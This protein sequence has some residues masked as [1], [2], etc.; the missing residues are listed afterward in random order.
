MPNAIRLSAILIS[1]LLLAAPAMAERGKSF[2]E[3]GPYASVGFGAAFDFLED[4]IEEEFPIADIETGWSANA[5]VGYRTF[6]WLSFELL[7]EGMYAL[8]FTLDG[9]HVGRT[10]THGLYG[11]FKLVAPIWRFQPY[12][13]FGL[14][15]QFGKWE[16]AVGILDASRWDFA[17]R[18]AIG[19]DVAL[20][21]NW[22]LFTELGLPVRFADWGDIPSEITDNVTLSVGG[23]IQYRF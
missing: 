8:D 22:A 3:P 5:R 12:F 10:T 2:N 6:S 16:G 7:Y 14:G 4:I 20:T 15:A 18:P 13:S 21:E 9:A 1:A 17:I 19:L 11:A 23:G